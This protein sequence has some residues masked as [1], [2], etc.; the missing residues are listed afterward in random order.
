M[1]VFWVVVPCGLVGRYQHSKEHTASIIR[2]EVRSVVEIDG[3]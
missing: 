3:S 1:L 2:V